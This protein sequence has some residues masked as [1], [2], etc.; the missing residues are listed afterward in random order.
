MSNCEEKSF[1]MGTEPEKNIAWIILL[2]YL[3]VLF[4]DSVGRDQNPVSKAM[5]ME[6][7]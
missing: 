7:H 4:S 5:R 2:E 1:R 6:E 3:D